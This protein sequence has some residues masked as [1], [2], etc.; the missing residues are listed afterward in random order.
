MDF[1]LTIEP[2]GG[3]R[4]NKG[5]AESTAGA[6]GPVTFE[7]GKEE[8]VFGREP[9]SDVV[10]A[11]EDRIVS[12]KHFRLY[13]QASGDYA[14]EVFGERYVELNGTPATSG[15]A[16]SDG[17]VIRL[18]SKDGP[19]FRIGVKEVAAAGGLERTL[20]QV[21]V[22]R[23]GEQFRRLRRTVGA[24]AVVVIAVGIGSYFYID[25]Q[26]GR[27]DALET[28]QQEIDR[29]VAADFNSND[30]AQFRNAT[31]AVV[32]EGKDGSRTFLGTAWPVGDGWLAT[33]AH[34]ADKFDPRGAR[35]LLVLHP[36]G[37]IAHTVTDAWIHP[38]YAALKDFRSKEGK[39]DPDFNA[40]FEGLPQP[41]GFDV[42]LLKVDQPEKLDPAFQ[43]ATPAEIA[44]LAPGAKLAYAGYPVE[45]TAA[46]RTA[47][48][49]PEPSVKFGYASSITD[50][51]LF[52]TDPKQAYLIRHS[53][54]ASGGAS[55][56]PIFIPNGHVVA[57]LS[58][59]TVFDAGG[60]RQPSAV[61]ENFAQRVDLLNARFDPASAFDVAANRAYWKDEILPRFGRLRQQI[62]SDAMAELQN[63][64]PGR[65]VVETLD[66]KASL[67]DHGVVVAGP[68]A[69]SDHEVNVE[70]GRRYTFLAYGEVGRTLS[71]RLFRG[72]KAI[73]FAGT[74]T[75]FASIDFPS[76]ATETLT[77]RVLG[78][79][80]NPVDYELFV[81][82]TEGASTADA[83]S[84]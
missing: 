59:G 61:L 34:V 14:I 47:A 6:T 84:G 41:S 83:S 8:I 53:I 58:G 9:A 66:L 57:V 60:E 45:G 2:L 43:L 7:A 13:R 79:K 46:E 54:P 12:R 27:L 44:A 51:F 17:D 63:T 1:S 48:E 62:V 64:A 56:S 39:A 22:V 77:L 29:K 33:N 11:P 19:A 31:Y 70:A 4:L 69:Y 23:S 68:V 78:E 72:D 76:E 37:K 5:P 18:G 49:D 67:G 26:A 35:K 21:K 82:T 65:K 30:I 71:L 50:F 52:N 25:Y 3:A 16:V 80:Q 81:M 55:G 32:I 36:G 15:E 10:F 38:G 28:L 42:A 75:S 24:L 40:A 73:G 20:T 74:G